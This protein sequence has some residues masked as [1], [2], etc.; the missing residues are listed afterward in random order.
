MNLLNLSPSGTPKFRLN[1]YMMDIFLKKWNEAIL[2]SQTYSRIPPDFVCPL[3]I[4]KWPTFIIFKSIVPFRLLRE[5]FDAAT[6]EF[7]R[8]SW[9]NRRMTLICSLILAFCMSSYLWIPMLTHCD[10]G[11]C[12]ERIPS[13]G[14]SPLLQYECF[15]FDSDKQI[16]ASFRSIY[17]R[18]NRI[19]RKKTIISYCDMIF[20]LCIQVDTCIS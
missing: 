9:S 15:V 6:N 11:V 2:K 16:E 10:L 19:S 12:S 17:S 5:F 4:S 13:F 1:F 3:K 8:I 18:Y 7:L 14:V 20:Y